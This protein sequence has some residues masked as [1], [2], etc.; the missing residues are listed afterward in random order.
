M[1]PKAKTNA[2]KFT[3]FSLVL[4]LVYLAIKVSGADSVSDQNPVSAENGLSTLIAKQH[5]L[6]H[7]Q[8]SSMFA[9]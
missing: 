9:A 1:D 5:L 2:C 4:T 6:L 8:A 3:E 7:R